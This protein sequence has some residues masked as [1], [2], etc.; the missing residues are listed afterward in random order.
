LESDY[1]YHLGLT[2]QDAPKF[3]NVRVVILGT[4]DSAVVGFAK[5]YSADIGYD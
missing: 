4:L 3:R 1:L 2:K 5:N